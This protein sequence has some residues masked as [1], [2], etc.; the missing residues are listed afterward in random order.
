MA[1]KVYKNE[2]DLLDRQIHVQRV[3]CLR[4][5]LKSS[6][7][8]NSCSAVLYLACCN[9]ES[10]Y[11]ISFDWIKFLHFI[12]CMESYLGNDITDVGLQKL[13]YLWFDCIRHTY[14][15]YIPVSQD[16][17]PSSSNHFNF[18][19]KWLDQHLKLDFLRNCS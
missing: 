2:S 11:S 15:T 12:V 3:K 19:H 7:L 10:P 4:S 14:N 8:Q 5:Y 18:I 17:W 9:R 6:Y 16:Y 1:V 13:N